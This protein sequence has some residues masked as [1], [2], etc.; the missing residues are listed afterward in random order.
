MADNR[1]FALLPQ[2]IY[3]ILCRSSGETM[4]TIGLSAKW[5]FRCRYLFFLF[6]LWANAFC[7]KSSVSCK[8][9]PAPRTFFSE[10][11]SSWCF[12]PLDRETR[13]PRGF[14]LVEMSTEEE[15]NA[16]I[17]AHNGKT[18]ISD[19]RGPRV[20]TVNEARPKKSVLQVVSIVVVMVVEI[21]TAVIVGKDFSEKFKILL[22]KGSSF[23]HLW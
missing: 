8:C 4:F 2:K 17:E 1:V 23:S 16:A 13:R 3:T 11:W 14:A 6:Q 21:V 7:R 15:A 5:R 10:W 20:I 19:D 18:E 22:P 9:W 12:I